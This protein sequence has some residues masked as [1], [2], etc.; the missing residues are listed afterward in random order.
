MKGFTF[1]DDSPFP[2]FVVQCL[3]IPFDLQIGQGWMVSAGGKSKEDLQTIKAELG[4]V[5]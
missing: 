3:A 2:S 1:C 5:R 4:V